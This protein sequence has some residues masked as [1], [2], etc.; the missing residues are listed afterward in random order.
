MTSWR[1]VA[2]GGGVAAAAAVVAFVVLRVE[3]LASPDVQHYMH[4][5]AYMAL[6]VPAAVR[7]RGRL[8]GLL[9]NRAA[10][11]KQRTDFR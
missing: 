5:A 2:V 9:D 1:R 8:V 6:I 10:K 7:V 3:A 4:I 11:R